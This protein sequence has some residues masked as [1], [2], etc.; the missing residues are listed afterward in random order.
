MDQ[1]RQQ[2]NDESGIVQ[3]SSGV[4]QR[5]NVDEAVRETEREAGKRKRPQAGD[6]MERMERDRV[7]RDVDRLERSMDEGS[8]SIASTSDGA[9][10]GDYSND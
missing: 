9:T 1:Q 6:G 8:E 7:E 3:D 4:V 2:H 5:E 10:R